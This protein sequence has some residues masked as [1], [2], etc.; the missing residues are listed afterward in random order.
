[1]KKSLVRAGSVFALSGAIIFGVAGSAG[2][3]EDSTD[4]TALT[5]VQVEES[6]TDDSA[7]ADDKEKVKKIKEGKSEKNTEK[8]PISTGGQTDK[9]EKTGFTAGVIGLG[10]AGMG[11]IGAGLLGL[12]KRDEVES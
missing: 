4:D 9:L 11:V 2:A 10:A 7:P 1:M 5:T 12:R 6:A 3:Q 8:G